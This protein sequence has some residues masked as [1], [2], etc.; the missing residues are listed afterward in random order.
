MVYLMEQCTVFAFPSWSEGF[1]LPPIEAMARGCAVVT[2]END[3]TSQYVRGCENCLLVSPGS[4]ED[5]TA[6]ISRLLDDPELRS[7][8]GASGIE[9]ASQYT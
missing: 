5:L 4:L 6:A 8:L 7:R 3:G 9:T 1:G 2:T